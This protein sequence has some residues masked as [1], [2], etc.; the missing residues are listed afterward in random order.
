MTTAI[1]ID[2]HFLFHVFK[3]NNIWYNATSVKQFVDEVTKTIHIQ[4]NEHLNDH[5]IFFYDC[6]FF[7]GYLMTKTGQKVLIDGK[8]HANTMLLEQLKTDTNFFI[9]EGRM[10]PAG[11]QL[12]SDLLS[13]GSAC[14]IQ[15][16]K[17]GKWPE[18]AYEP[19]FKQKGIDTKITMDL[20]KLKDDPDVQQIVLVSNDS[21]FAPVIDEVKLTG[22]KVSV[23]S[24]EEGQITQPLR[25]ACG[26]SVYHVRFPDQLKAPQ[27]ETQQIPR[28]ISR[29]VALPN[30]RSEANQRS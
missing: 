19:I 2:A 9:K 20:L 30:M 13:N 5:K 22:K 11:W 25:T 18:E 14:V 17:E 23:L 24:I 16:L 21:D 29:K 28:I 26:N 27:T 12:K 15:A 4:N 8:K 7:S 6:A 1:L 10:R 3:D